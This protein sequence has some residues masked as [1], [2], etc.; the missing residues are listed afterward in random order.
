MRFSIRDL[1]W[2]TALV[3][4]GLG[5]WASY[6]ALTAKCSEYQSDLDFENALSQLLRKKLDQAESE[7]KRLTSRHTVEP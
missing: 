1:L 2:V 5:W 4:M 6:T 3:A 7:I